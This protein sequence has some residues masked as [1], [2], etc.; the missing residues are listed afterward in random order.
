MTPNR[1]S[2]LILLLSSFILHPSSFSLFAAETDSRVFELRTYHAAPGKLDALHARFR[3][4][5]VKLFAKHGIANIGYWV[6]LENDGNVLTYIVA[7]PDR[8]ARAKS[9][10]A[11]KDDPDWK[12][13]YTASRVDGKLVEKVDATFMQLTDYSP[14]VPAS[15]P[16]GKTVVELR[17]YTTNPGKLPNINARFRDHT[18][19]LF[20]KH[21]ITNL[22]YFNLMP[23]EEG[24]GNTLVYLIAHDD[25]ESRDASFKSFGAD[26][27]W[28]KVAT[29]SQVDGRILIKKGVQSVLMQ[30]TD[31]SPL[32]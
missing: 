2:F 1:S 20:E 21:G 10:K 24:A 23:G 25:V 3:D 18:I 29:E 11:F 12:A 30:A 32:K 19:K 8:D 22:P 26:P 7:Y 4:H 17:T 31:Y 28:K 9:W 6:P 5:T 16:S 13:A 27:A 14:A 15:L